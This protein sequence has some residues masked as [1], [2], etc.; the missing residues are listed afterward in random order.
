[1][2]LAVQLLLVSYGKNGRGREPAKVRPEVPRGLLLPRLDGRGVLHESFLSHHQ[3]F[4]PQSSLVEV[5][6]NADGV[7]AIKG[8]L[9]V[10]VIDDKAQIAEH[11]PA[12]PLRTRSLVS[13]PIGAWARALVDECF[14]A[15]EAR[16]TR[17][18]IVNAGLFTTAPAE[19]IFLGEPSQLID[20]RGGQPS[21]GDGML[22]GR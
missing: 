10:R 11:H 1:M 9:C 6:I 5:P 20:A 18:L 7:V 16:W 14:V 15:G 12:E 19:G 17:E 4:A 21:G 3:G 13:V 2:Y 8:G 22:S